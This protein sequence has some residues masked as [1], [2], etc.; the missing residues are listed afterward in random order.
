MDVRRAVRDVV[1]LTILKMVAGGELVTMKIGLAESL[2][3]LAA[4]ADSSALVFAF[5]DVRGLDREQRIVADVPLL[6]NANDCAR[7][8][9]GT[10]QH[11]GHARGFL[12][13]GWFADALAFQ[14]P[15]RKL[16]LAYAFIRGIQRLCD[17]LTVNALA[18]QV[19]L[20]AA[21]AEAG[22]LLA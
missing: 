4:L 22:V 10:H 14:M 7:R 18:H 1:Q 21:A 16:L 2:T 5:F 20:H 15:P 19:L 8:K 3:A 9:S 17:H 6:Q 13:A 12:L 11:A